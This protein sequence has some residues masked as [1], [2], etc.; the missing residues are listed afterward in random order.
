MT[1]HRHIARVLASVLVLG[2]LAAPAGAQEARYELGGG[3]LGGAGLEASA[4]YRDNY[5]YE[6]GGKI[7]AYGFRVRPQVGVGR[8]SSLG[9]LA[10]DAY[11]DHTRYDLPGKLDEYVD[12]GGS[13][14]FDWRP[15]A[16]HAF[17]LTGGYKRSHDQPGLVRTEDGPQF[18]VGEVDE[19]DETRLGLG[20]SYGSASASASNKLSVGY[21]GREYVTNRGATRFLNY[22]AV[23]LG[24]Q[25]SYAYSP[26]T[27]IVLTANH[28]STDYETRGAGGSRRDGNE[29]LVRTG[30]RW[31]ASGKTSGQVLVGARSYSVDDRNRAS[32]EGFSW[33]A[34][35]EWT[36][37]SATTLR[38]VTGQTTTE[39]YRTD[40]FFIDN[41]SVSLNWRQFWTERLSSTARFGYLQSDF[42]G[43]NR[44]DDSLDY[45]FGIGYTLLRQVDLF[46]DYSVTERNSSR[47]NLDFEAPQ[48]RVGLNW[49]L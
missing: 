22:D 42:V 4:I 29:F 19:W 6:P 30:L 12:Y 41:R 28:N 25:L 48:A 34:D 17:D 37:L 31:I 21:R 46:A 33:R 39:T 24:Y 35:V 49:T 36:P 40:T 8:S 16:K 7:S 23:Q 26:K 10:L 3:F 14:R 1:S 2:G 11:L 5:F 43:S 32:R 13:G 9:E 27:S 47:T 44:K 18:G 15:L 38:L 45:G 20:Y